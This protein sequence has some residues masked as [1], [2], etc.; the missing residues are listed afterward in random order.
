MSAASAAPP[1]LRQYLEI[2]AG[3]HVGWDPVNAVMI[4]HW[5]E[6]MGDANPL[7]SDAAVASAAGYAGPI[8]PPA[9]LQAWVM[10]GLSGPAPGS[11]QDQSFAVLDDLEARGYPAIV[12]V[13]C[14]QEYLAALQIGDRLR[15]HA[16]IEDIS[17]EKTTQ[18]GVGY[19]IT[20]LITY[21]N[22][23]DEVVGRMRF[24]VLKYRPHPAAEQG[25]P[26]AA[27]AQPA[28]EVVQRMRPARNHD[29]AF[30]WEGVELG[31]LRAQRCLGC[32]A[33][34]HP[35]SPACPA[36]QSLRWEIAPCAGRGEVYSY[37]V[38]HYPQFPPFD[39][40]NTVALIALDEG[41]RLLSN[42]VGVRAD[43]VRI[44]MRVAVAFEE[45]EPG[46]VLP[47]FRPE[48][49]VADQD[50]GGPRFSQLRVGER[51]AELALDITPTLIVSGAL[52]SRDFEHVHHDRTGA[53]SLG[54]PDIFMN[55]LTSN[56]LVAR[57]VTDW[58]G[59]NARLLKLAIRL[60]APNYP[61]DRM[62]LSG[63]LSELDAAR[64]TV[65]VAIKG[66]NR[67]GYHVTGTAQLELPA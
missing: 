3:P 7:Y 22:Q 51:L 6:A 59:P 65:T 60:G 33:I 66:T 31:E 63:E 67:L 17:A 14:E 64:R 43:E 39:Y 58:S 2:E 46:L 47:L 62:T 41:F 11:S 16:H 29:N 25:Q 53:Q 50:A 36:C 57:F 44:G 48:P 38:L 61:G 32:D 30:F 26:A 15:M 34:R 19:F 28:A 9:M 10:P 13:N 20:Q 12:A 27:A 8:A 49:P 35:P 23:R 5:C 54:S 21:R 42:V 37:T 18:L 40:P 56:G 52:A 1:E 45:V 4:R 55:I 24:R